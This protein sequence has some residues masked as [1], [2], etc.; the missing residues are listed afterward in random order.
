MVSVVDVTNAAP[1]TVAGFDC[2]GFAFALALVEESSFKRELSAPSSPAC[3]P[4]PVEW[5]VSG[6]NLVSGLDEGLPPFLMSVLF[7]LLSSLSLSL[8]ASPSASPLA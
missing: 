7:S 5:D 4:P 2:F 1:S 6:F 3:N 8:V